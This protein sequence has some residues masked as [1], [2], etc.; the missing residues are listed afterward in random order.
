MSLTRNGFP[1]FVNTNNP[2]G[3]VGNFASMNP[4]ANVVAGPGALRAASG[5]SFFGTKNPIVGNF[6]WVLAGLAYSEKPAG[7]NLQFGFV[8]NE[9]Q[10]I[11]VQFLAQDRLAIEGGFPV[12]LFTRGDFW[13]IARA[14]TSGDVA[15]GSTVYANPEDGSVTDDTTHFS[16][17]GVQVAAS[18][19][20]TVSAV[21]KGKLLVGDVI[22]GTGVDVGLTVTAQ[23]TGAPGAAGTYTVST[24]TG[25]ASTTITAANVNTGFTFLT[26]YA[27]DAAFT[28]EIA[29]DTGVLTASAVTG[30]ILTA[31]DADPV[32]GNGPN[33]NGTGVPANLFILSQLSGTPGGAGD[34]QLNYQGAAVA[35]TAMTASQ[36]K[37]VKIGRTF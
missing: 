11:I 4:R 19:T 10:T 20:L 31:A 3:I 5:V 2:P 21:T 13:T 27:A 34:Y 6:A 24:T 8:A 29:A 25:F 15:A 7:S 33:L 17:T 1:S 26:G 30:T 28:G 36:G 32:R 16:A 23:L 14:P 22:A 9:G 37:M 12:T 18:S 35:S